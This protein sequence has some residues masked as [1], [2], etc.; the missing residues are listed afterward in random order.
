MP[1]LQPQA[2]PGQGSAENIARR[3]RTQ[4]EL[5]AESLPAT[6]AAA[7][8]AAR[9]ETAGD[10]TDS[11]S[12]GIAVTRLAAP[13]PQLEIAFFGGGG[14]ASPCVKPGTWP[15]MEVKTEAGAGSNA[16]TVESLDAAAGSNAAK[17]SNVVAGSNVAVVVI[18][19]PPSSAG[20]GAIGSAP[21]AQRAV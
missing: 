4:P 13:E 5:P 8:A 10:A 3:T 15:R 14:T 16:A 7:K 20:L 21:P 9:A 18:P 1:R 17:G 12:I 11:G 6:A 19:K 2:R